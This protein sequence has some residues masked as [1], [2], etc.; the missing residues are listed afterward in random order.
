[1]YCNNNNNNVSLQEGQYK[2]IKT[3]LAYLIY[4]AYMLA[5]HQQQS[6]KRPNKIA[7]S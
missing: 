7:L 4:L 3:Y 1:M 5:D 6:R 2:R